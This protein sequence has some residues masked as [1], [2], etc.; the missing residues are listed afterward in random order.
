MI[1]YESPLPVF[2][3]KKLHIC[4]HLSADEHYGPADEAGHANDQDKKEPDL[5]QQDDSRHSFF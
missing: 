4:H 2:A 5:E 1:L 3:Q